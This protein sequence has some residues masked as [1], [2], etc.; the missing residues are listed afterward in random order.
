ML[1][2]IRVGLGGAILV[3]WG[4]REVGFSGDLRI[5]PYERKGVD[6]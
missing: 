5:I 2:M 4:R 6:T 1:S 3:P